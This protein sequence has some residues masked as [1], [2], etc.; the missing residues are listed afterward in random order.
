MHK[1]YNESITIIL[2]LV[3]QSLLKELLMS[4]PNNDQR[5]S[6]ESHDVVL[7]AVVFATLLILTTCAREDWVRQSAGVGVAFMVLG[8]IFISAMCAILNRFGDQLIGKFDRLKA[9]GVARKGKREIR[10]LSR[11]R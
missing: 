9:A 3:S 10:R 1:C 2:W 6:S 11:G 4:N 5:Q 7:G 8:T